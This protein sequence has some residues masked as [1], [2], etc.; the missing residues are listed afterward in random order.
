MMRGLPLATNSSVP[1]ELLFRSICSSI[2]PK[3]YA[4]PLQKTV[5]IIDDDPQYRHIVSEILQ[6]N[7]WQVI[8]ASEG[9]QGIALA[10]EHRPAVV[11]CDLLMPRCNGYHVCRA[12]RGEPALRHLK[13]VIAS[14]RDFDTD[15]QAASAEGADEYLTKPINPRQ[16]VVLMSRI[17]A[18]ADSLEKPPV[19]AG[20]KAKSPGWLKF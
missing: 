19:P 17:L 8:E 15:R 1:F 9:D 5:L 13:I 3:D 14:G 4:M 6:E 7:G 18:K 20:V 12:L 2:A 10:K 11:L 16:L